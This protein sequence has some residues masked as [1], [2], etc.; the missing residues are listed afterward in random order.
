MNII[1][2]NDREMLAINVANAL[3]GELE[4]ALLVHDVISFAVPGGTTPG[5]V[6]DLLSAT[7]LDWGRIRVMLTDERWVDVDHEMSNTRLIKERLLT[8]KAGAAQFVPFYRAGQSA[9]AGSAE[10][11]AILKGLFPLSVLMLGMGGDMHTASLFPGA[12]GVAEA[13]A[14]DAPLL[15]PIKVPD[16]DIERVTLPAHVLEG[17]LAKHLVI[18]G[19]DKR[20][21]LERAQNLPPQEAPIGAV[22]TGAKIHWAA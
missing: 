7:D 19:D 1:Q 16:Q 3:A 8:G 21:A 2:Y 11:S 12:Q 20:A 4:N 17:A 9:A 13:F 22:L 5:P 15:C 6:F 14:D 18:F 10:V